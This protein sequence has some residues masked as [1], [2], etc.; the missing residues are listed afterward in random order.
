[1]CGMRRAAIIESFASTDGLRTRGTCFS[2]S[3]A[4]LR[5]SF[6]SRFMVLSLGSGDAAAYAAPA[7]ARS[8]SAII[9]EKK[10]FRHPVTLPCFAIHFAAR[11]LAANLPL[12]Y[13]TTQKNGGGRAPH[14]R[15]PPLCRSYWFTACAY[16]TKFLTS[17]IDA[18]FAERAIVP[19]FISMIAGSSAMPSFSTILP[20]L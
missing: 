6:I 7:A 5:P 16:A 2:I 4:L 11:V 9:K 14:G 17:S 19:F 1:M 3:A 20:F 10:F 15:L 8:A 18:G 13:Y 12:L